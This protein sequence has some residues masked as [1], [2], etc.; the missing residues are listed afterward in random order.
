VSGIHVLTNARP[1]V[2]R[3]S[4]KKL[5]RFLRLAKGVTGLSLP[6]QPITLHL[7]DRRA[8]YQ[9][10]AGA[11]TAGHAVP[12]PHRYYIALGSDFP[13]WTTEI[14]FHEV[15]HLLLFGMREP[16][17]PWYHEGYAEYLASAI[18]RPGVATL[19]RPLPDRVGTLRSREPM[20]LIRLFGARNAFSLP[21]GEVS[22]YYAEAWAFV[23]FTQVSVQRDRR[24]PQLSRFLRLLA[25]GE[26][27]GEAFASAFEV[28]V[29]TV[30]R[31][32]RLHRKQLAEGD[33]VLYR[34]YLFEGEDPAIGFLPA[35]GVAVARS[36]AAHALAVPHYEVAA[37]HYG[38]VLERAA[39]D[40][41][42]L[43]GRSIALA[44][45]GEFPAA[46]REASAI[47]SDDPRSFEARGEVVMQR[48]E[49]LDR[50]KREGDEAQALLAE[51]YGEFEVAVRQDPSCERCWDRIALYHAR[52]PR[53]DPEQGLEAIERAG[54]LS[55]RNLVKG[56]LL[57]RLGRFEAARDYVERRVSTTHDPSVARDGNSLLLRIMREQ[58]AAREVA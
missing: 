26:G 43:L 47:P 9:A 14:L 21:P 6:P 53:G 38:E 11:G 40:P 51:A 37:R 20:P 18:M 57:L 31:R 41:E 17:P 44:S 8:Q 54:P 55:E 2:A 29:G 16:L 34:H 1:E 5:S 7:F 25:E 49:R 3:R 22:L 32:Y 13:E 35:S 10:F 30:E 45:L 24:A 28:T 12:A 4:L 23:H 50:S 48:Y 56:E 27:V 36:L 33:E 19:G 46:D 58:R 42:A 39:G 15:V 52:H